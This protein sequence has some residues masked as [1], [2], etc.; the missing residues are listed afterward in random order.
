MPTNNALR[1]QWSAAGYR[2]GCGSSAVVPPPPQNFIRVYYIT[3]AEHAISDIGLGRIKVARFSDLNDPFELM[4]ANFRERQTRKIVRNFKNAYDSH[5]GLLCFSADWI[6]PVLWSHYGVKHRGICL[7]FNLERSRAQKVRYEDERLLAHIGE[8]NELGE[9]DN[10]LRELLLCTKFRHWQYE[11]EYRVFLPLEDVPQE[12]RLHFYSFN[13]DLQL[14]EVILGP[15][16]NLS[17]DA[18]RELTRTRYSNAVTYQAR[19]AWKWF[20]VVPQ[21]ST[22][23]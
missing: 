17:L 13:Q 7:G 6:N 9:I 11:E 2:P 10:E 20:A 12:G 22:V 8:N 16:C 3:S 14:A 15:Q 4:A 18:V 1:A 5:T 21:E 19:L 23:P